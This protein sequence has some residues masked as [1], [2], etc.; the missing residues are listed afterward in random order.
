M[1]STPY[2]K[3]FVKNATL[4][5]LD[6]TEFQHFLEWKADLMSLDL[7]EAVVQSCFFDSGTGVSCQFYEISKNTFFYRTHLVAASDFKGL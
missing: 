1:R 7:T 3:V 2:K 4:Q 6:T 5:L